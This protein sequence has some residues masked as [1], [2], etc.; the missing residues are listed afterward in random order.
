MK[1]K[2]IWILLI[3]LLT[4]SVFFVG[5]VAVKNI[6][7]IEKEGEGLLNIDT[8][9][10]EYK[11]GE[12]IMLIATPSPGWRFKEWIGDVSN[13]NDTTTTVIM[14]T[15]KTVKVVFEEI[16][17]S[18]TI[19]K[20]GEGEVTKSPDKLLYDLGEEIMLTATPSPGWKFIKW[21]DEDDE[22][23]S[24][25]NPYIFTIP[26]EDITLKG[27]FEEIIQGHIPGELQRHTVEEVIF[28]MK[29]VPGT[30][31]PTGD[32]TIPE[33]EKIENSYWLGKTTVTYELWY[34]VKTWATD[35]ARGEE[36]YTFSNSGR[37]GSNGIDG[38]VPSTAKNE[39]VTR[40][41]WR[42][43]IVWVN[44]LSEMLDLDPVYRHEGAILRDANN[45]I[46]ND[47]EQTN[48]NGFRLPTK[49]EWKLAARYIG[50]EKPVQSPLKEEALFVDGI[51]WTPREYASGAFADNN[52]IAETSTVAWYDVNSEGKTHD[53]GL[54]RANQLGIYDMSGNVW[55]WTFTKSGNNRIIRGGS[56]YNNNAKL[57][58]QSFDG[59]NWK[60]DGIGF[61]LAR[62]LE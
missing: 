57:M 12:E 52:D 11:T 48:N 16:K 32:K 2:K 28:D 42:D 21:T 13:N 58:S 54:L 15:D 4:I 22:E 61:R 9:N 46:C 19:E 47:A 45:D 6:L 17:S 41:S 33:I 40:V 31:F 24:S 53:V 30:N 43:T 51:W 3:I 7:T 8:G 49:W 55:E 34:S 56:Y 10:H 37:E 14:N 25:A 20:V 39:P 27:I 50:V 60:N 62:T 38:A 5:C 36:K 44:A 59:T 18:L 35:D 29:L 1:S 26:L 23:I